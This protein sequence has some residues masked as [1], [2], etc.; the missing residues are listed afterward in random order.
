MANEWL[1]NM[2]GNKISKEAAESQGTDK[3]DHFE[4]K[5]AAHDW[6]KGVSDLDPIAVEAEYQEKLKQEAMTLGKEA[7]LVASF[8][9]IKAET[10]VTPTEV[11]N[12]DF[13]RDVRVLSDYALA[14]MLAEARG[15]K[16]QNSSEMFYELK[17]K[18]K[19]EVASSREKAEKALLELIPD[20]TQLDWQKAFKTFTDESKPEEAKE[21]DLFKTEVPEKAHDF[22]HP[23]EEKFKVPKDQE[24]AIPGNGREADERKDVTEEAGVLKDDIT[25]GLGK[26][27][28]AMPEAPIEDTASVDKEAASNMAVIESFISGQAGAK[29]TNLTIV[30]NKNGLMLVNYQTPIA[31]R[32][33][34]GTVYLNSQKYSVTTSKIQ[35]FIR[36]AAGG[37]VKE[38]S[39][40]DL[41]KVMSEPAVAPVAEK[42]AD[43]PSATDNCPVCSSEGVDLNNGQM[44]HLSCQACGLTYASKEPLSNT[45]NPDKSG[46]TEEEHRMWDARHAGEF[47]KNRP[48]LEEV[49]KRRH[50]KNEKEMHPGTASLKNNQEITAQASK[51]EVIKIIKQAEVQS[52]WKIVLD[53]DGK[54]CIARVENETKTEKVSEEDKTEELQK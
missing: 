47:G 6:I 42:T 49:T 53:A 36:R 17:E 23:T 3:Q 13:Q 37:Q 18:A 28:A 50:D 4:R 30:E 43:G 24:D 44:D 31:F 8:E 22:Q 34:D 33:A 32:A 41:E 26:E 11:V 15:H 20:H 21:K 45:N 48:S 14:E 12:N 35:T 51:E 5:V 1:D 9:D 25:K 29:S 46:M 39:P 54:E 16:A 38:V 27:A 10:G 7:A 40:Q 2:L 19:K 52:P